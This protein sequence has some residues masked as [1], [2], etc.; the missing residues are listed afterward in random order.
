MGEQRKHARQIKCTNHSLCEGGG[1]VK[2]TTTN[3]DGQVTQHYSKEG[4]KAAC[5][6]EAR[7]RF[8]QANKT[9]FLKEPLL[10]DI[11]L[12][13]THLPMFDWIAAGTYQSPPGTQ[14]QA[15]QLLPLLTQPPQVTNCPRK[16]TG[17]Q[18]QQGWAKA[19]EMTSSSL[20]RAHFGHYK[21]GVTNKV[22]NS[23]YTMLMDIPLCTSSHIAGGKKESMLCWRK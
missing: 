16:I 4:I 18:H 10:L 20:S 21:A 11:Q 8:T 5:L 6:E 9:S 1:L 14:H 2:V 22:I 13:G 15:N 7:A 12:L 17:D 23:L 19:K 3:N